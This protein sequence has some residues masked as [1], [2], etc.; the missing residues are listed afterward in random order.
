MPRTPLAHALRALVAKTNR[1]EP[2]PH[3]AA[4][5]AAG[6]TRRDVIR[7]GAVAAGAAVAGSLPIS[8]ARG[9]TT[10]RVVV[11]G[12]GLAGLSATYKLQQA[13]IVADVFEASNRAGGRCW[14]RRNGFEDGQITERGGEFIDTGHTDLKRLARSLGLSLVDVHRAEKPGTVPLYYFDGAPYTNAQATSDYRAVRAQLEQDAAAAGYPTTHDSYTPRGFELDHTSVYQYIEQ[15]IPGGHGSRFGQLLDVA[16]NIEYGAET[17]QQSSLNLLYLLGLS[18]SPDFAI[19]GD[20]DERF[21]IDG[22]NDLLVDRL[23][24]KVGSQ[25]AYGSELTAID[26][27]VNGGYNLTF[28]QG[29]TTRTV[30]ADRVV[31]AI[32]FSILR[33]S[34]DY[35]QAEFR[36]LKK[37]AIRE[38]GMGANA[39]LAV[40]FEN[41]Y[42]RGQGN[43]GDTYSDTGY[44]NTWEVTRGQTGG[45]GILLDYTGGDAARALTGDADVLARRFCRQLEPVLPGAVARYNGH[46]KLDYWPGYPWT[47]GA[48][49]YWRVGQYTK[50]SG[51]EGKREDECHFCG[52]HTSQDFQG[53][54][55]GAVQTGQR[56][57]DEVVAALA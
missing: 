29:M 4:P 3:L 22:G 28:D 34:V 18:S 15:V 53:Y 48:Y 49:S 10:Q 11:V 17:G 1:E 45:S 21:K 33:S 39:K 43:N 16:Y 37:V 12:A 51:I 50:F 20:S 5:V 47:K 25:I 8:L 46:A 56:A 6:H 2:S 9:A 13:G 44:Q 42:W 14:T 32:P 19:F 31:M 7:G 57:A 55:N 40:Q 24:D 26:R 27:R 54:M 38:L 52:E 35:S 41:R 36:P 30:K 23:V